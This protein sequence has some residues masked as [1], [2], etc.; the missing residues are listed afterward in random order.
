MGGQLASDEVSSEK[1]GVNAEIAVKSTGFREI[2]A[3]DCYHIGFPQSCCV[4]K[5]ALLVV[6]V[7][8]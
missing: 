1:T 5:H 8:G 6:L 2:V 3:Y 7:V 4:G